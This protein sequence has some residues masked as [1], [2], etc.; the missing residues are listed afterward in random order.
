MY[1]DEKDREAV[2]GALMFILDK[3][4]FIVFVSFGMKGINDEEVT[5]SDVTRLPYILTISCQRSAI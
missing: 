5:Y 3:W 4:H 1:A 2:L